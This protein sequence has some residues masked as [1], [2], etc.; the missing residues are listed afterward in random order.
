MRI[1]L[2]HLTRYTYTRPVF[3]EPHTI[4]LTPRQ[5]ACQ[6]IVDHRLII[7]PAPAGR[8][9]GI[10]AEGNPFTQV[11]FDGLAPALTVEA[12]TT[13]ETLRDNP[14]AFLLTDAASLPPKFGPETLAA[15]APCLRQT[16]GP[17]GAVAE[18]ARDAASRAKG[19]GIDFLIELNTRIFNDVTKVVRREQGILP[20]ETVCRE[21]RGACRDSAALL[22]ACSRLAGVP[23][24][25]VS[26]Y[27]VGGTESR[28]EHDLHA[29][30][31]AFL[32][33][34]GWI[35]LDPTHGLVVADRH[36]ALVASHDPELAAPVRGSF[37]GAE[38]GAEMTHELELAFE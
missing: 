25:F 10:D 32:P 28:D 19:N 1:T 8:W 20:P 17:D 13:A 11:W 26:G 7:D 15:L 2:R 9:D 38:A 30:A 35:G 22:I 14:F 33:G 34:A 24:R 16:A 6:R 21:R 3:I 4:R 27:Q 29:W 23:A 31:E 37:R 18:L 36:L 12:L 5:D